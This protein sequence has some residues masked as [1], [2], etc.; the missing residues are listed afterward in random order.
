MQL[1]NVL[2]CCTFDAPSTMRSLSSGRPL[3]PSRSALRR[4]HTRRS[5]PSERRRVGPDPLAWSPSPAARG[6][7]SVIVLAA[8]LSARAMARHCRSLVT[9]GLDP[10]V[11]ADVTQANAGGSIRKRSF[12]MDCRIKSGNDERKERKSKAKRR[13]TQW[14]LCRAAGPG[15]APIGVRTSVG[16]PPRFSPQGVFHRKELSLRPGFLGR[17]EQVWPVR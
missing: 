17:G 12:G 3:P 2:L 5:S 6:R 13:Q 1:A 4:T 7:M 10:V 9:T 14:G 8:R 15:R 16:V 11:H